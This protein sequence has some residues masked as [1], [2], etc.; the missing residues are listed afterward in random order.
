MTVLCNPGVVLCN[1]GVVLC[2]PGVLLC[3]T[4][5]EFIDCNTNKSYLDLA[6]VNFPS[7]PG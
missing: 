4:D 2:N 1:T 6:M 7:C 3:N 5:F